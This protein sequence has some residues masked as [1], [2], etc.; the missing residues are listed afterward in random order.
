[1]LRKI[2]NPLVPR[3]DQ[4]PA[5]RII[6]GT[7]RG[8]TLTAPPSG[9]RPTSDR[10][11]ESLFSR[12]G[13][14]EGCRVLDLF[15]GSGALGIEALSRGAESLVAVDRAGRS[16]AAIER[17]LERLGVDDQARVMRSEARGALKRLAAA[18][19]R[20]DLVFLD[21]PYDADAVVPALSAL[22]ESG[23]L[24]SEATVV[25]ET[26]KRHPLE[27]VDGLVLRDQRTYGD[28]VLSW[29]VPAIAATHS[30]T[31]QD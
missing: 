6:A 2:R 3:P 20:F 28:T 5:L 24:G 15:A 16:V 12:L 23:V 30:A 18:G 7:L 29:L 13:D 8:R 4:E 25:V 1:M 21:P 26:A 17:N 10:V 27:P 22:V 19:E 9:V 31:G 11:R 14:V